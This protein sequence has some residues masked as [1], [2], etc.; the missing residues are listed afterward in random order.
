MNSLGTVLY[1]SRGGRAHSW[2]PAAFRA[3]APGVCHVI[4][5]KVSNSCGYSAPGYRQTSR[6]RSNVIRYFD[7]GFG[8]VSAG[9][10]MKREAVV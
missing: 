4:R 7:C 5:D 10:G 1:Y 3:G 8:A 9:S 2:V 6:G